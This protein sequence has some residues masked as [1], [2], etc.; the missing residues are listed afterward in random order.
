MVAPQNVDF[1]RVLDFVGEEQGDG[2]DALPAPVHIVA[3]EQVGRVGRE[4]PVF[5]QPEHVAVLAVDV[6][7]DFDWRLHFYKHVLAHENSLGQADDG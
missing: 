5:E 1:I 7:A 3:Q 2:L 6:A 4:T